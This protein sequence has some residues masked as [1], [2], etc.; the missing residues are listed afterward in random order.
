V[1]WTFFPRDLGNSTINFYRLVTVNI[2]YWFFST[3]TKKLH[4]GLW[5]YLAMM[6]RIT[7]CELLLITRLSLSEYFCGYLLKVLF[8]QGRQ[9]PRTPKPPPFIL[10]LLFNNGDEYDKDGNDLCNNYIR[11]DILQNPN[12]PVKRLISAS[13][14]ETVEGYIRAVAIENPLTPADFLLPLLGDENRYVREAV[15]LRFHM[16]T[17]EPEGWDPRGPEYNW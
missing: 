11:E 7:L 14:D 1:I 8:R 16:P 2:L 15:A 5:S 3:A 12:T 6:T 4:H 9:S 10:D 13:L 17:P